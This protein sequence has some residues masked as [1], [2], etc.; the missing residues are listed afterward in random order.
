MAISDRDTREREQH[1]RDFTESVSRLTSEVQEL[2]DRISHGIPDE[3]RNLERDTETQIDQ[4]KKDT[5]RQIDALRKEAAKKKD[6]LKG[7]ISKTT[8]LLRKKEQELDHVKRELQQLTQN[9][10]RM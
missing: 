4:L 5:E 7:E 8:P 6:E 2:N 10:G 3:I 1:Q 9:L